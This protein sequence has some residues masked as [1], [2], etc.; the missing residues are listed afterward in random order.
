VCTCT[1]SFVHASYGAGRSPGCCCQ[2]M[3]PATVASRARSF[4][5]SVGNHSV[6][7]LPNTILCGHGKAVHHGV[8][9]RCYSWQTTASTGDAATLGCSAVPSLTT[10]CGPHRG[11]YLSLSHV[12]AQVEVFWTGTDVISK[13]IT[14]EHC[15]EVSSAFGGRWLIIWDN[16]HANDYDNGRRVFLGPLQYVFPL[17]EPR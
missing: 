14:T 5:K 3:L 9:L 4:Q 13:T 7:V 12:H 8:S 10:R 17:L 16:L 11:I 1:Q 2:P 15:R 6:R